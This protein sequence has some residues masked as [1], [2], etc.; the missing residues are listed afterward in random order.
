MQECFEGVPC[1]IMPTW[2][3]SDTM[4]SEFASFDLVI[5]DEASQSDITALPAILRAKKLLIVGDDKQVSPTAAFVSEEK[6]QQFSQSYL[7]SQPFADL[8][9]PGM[10]LYD[11]ASAIYPTQRIML[12]EHFRCV[13]P[14][15]RFSMKFYGNE[16]LPLRLPKASEKIEPPL[17]D[18]YVK[19]GSRDEQRGVNVA[20][21]YAIVDEIKLLTDDVRFK[22]RSIG[23]ISL[24]G[25]EQAQAIQ[26]ALLQELGEETYQRYKIACGDSAMF[27]GKEK[28]VI[29]LSMVVGPKQGSVLNKREYEQ[30]F[31]VAL[32]RAR[33]RMYLVRSVSDSDLKNPTDL[34]VQV[35]RHFANPM[36]KRVVS[37]NP[38]DLC[39][40]RFEKDIAARLLELEYAVMPHVKV[41]P[42]DIDI[43]VESNDGQRIAIELDGDQPQS[44][45]EWE[46][47]IDNQRILER[48][49]WVYWRCWA[50]SYRLN[51]DA[52]FEDLLSALKANKVIPSTPSTPP[53]SYTEYKEI[54]NIEQSLTPVL[55]EPA[56]E[57][58]AAEV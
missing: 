5:I 38:L 56:S 4:P 9:I 21:I 57:E 40:T 47:A 35:L 31:N 17:V 6:I 34:R 3:I 15:I 55:A 22:N 45:E 43:V 25:S 33:D 46:H 30:R 27:Q 20:E 49:G 8:L 14:I 53:G 44:V 19:G 36:P 37:D 28:D 50:A 54:S 23:V 7:R 18:V 26:D 48:V 16:L 13:E 32:S 1:W 10:S 24:I 11:L 41:G 52:C 29:F 2:R 51:P 42:I 39:E 12:T 58:L